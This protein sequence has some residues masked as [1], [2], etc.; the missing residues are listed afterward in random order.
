VDIV[1]IDEKSPQFEEVVEL[2]R[3]NAATLGFLPRGA[4]RQYAKNSQLLV[5]LDDERR[6]LGYLLYGTTRR[7]MQAYIVHLCV[8]QSQRGKG[9]AETLFEELKEATKYTFHG[10]RVHCRRDYEANALWPK[11]GFIATNEMPGRSKHRS[12]LT[13]WWFDHGHPTLFTYADAQRIQSRLKVAIDANVFFQLQEPRTPSNEESQSLLV[14]W[15]QENIELCVTKE[16]F[17]EIDRHPDQ[18]ERKR[19]RAFAESFSILTSTDDEFQQAKEGLRDFF[20]EKMST[21]DE[22]DLRQ[23]ARSIAAGVQFFITRDR[24]LLGKEERAYDKFGIRIIHPSDLVTNQDQIIRETEYYPARLAGSQIKIERVH[25]GQISFLVETFCASQ[26]ETQAEFRQQLHRCLAD[27]YAHEADVVRSAGN[28]LA[29]IIHRLQNQR[30][31][32]IPVF[33]VV[34]GTLS[35]TLARHLVLRSVLVSCREDR[36]L[37]KITDPYLSDDVIDALQEIGFFFADGYWMKANLLVIE[38]AQELVS[39]LASLSTDF[40]QASQYFDQMADTLRSAQLS[41]VPQSM[42]QIERYLWPA[43]L[44][45]LDIPAFVIP[46]RPEWAM[47]LFDPHIARQDLF[48]AEPSLIFNSENV[49]YRASRPEVLSSPARVLWYVSKGRGVYQGT[50][51][52]RAC[53]YVD[54]VVIDKPKILFSRFR[55]M[56]VY[57]WEDVL[58]VAK[59][60]L[61]REIMAFRFSNTEVFSSPIEIDDLQ[62]IWGEKTGGQFHIQSPIAIPKQ[63]FFRLYKMGMRTQ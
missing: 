52:I 31:L 33:R 18:G 38:T 50:M 25:S 12:T 49:Y 23:L 53:S 1:T 3:A 32:E 59:R 58:K 26:G 60:S 28:P 41:G 61:G 42:L 29:F 51:S 9:I 5:A 11:L 15:L 37:T 40:P 57:Q 44:T 21:S 30:E 14:D 62:R 46:I 2:G 39:R 34:R 47:H 20:P 8:A 19:G 4:F 63:R 6:V 55:R 16:I 22:S 45:D 36:V 54:E 35:A 10:I 13:V 24:E 17:N 48:G 7:K 56:G 43:K 27:P